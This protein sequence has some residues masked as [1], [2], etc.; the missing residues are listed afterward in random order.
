[1]RTWDAGSPLT[2]NPRAPAKFDTEEDYNLMRRGFGGSRII[3]IGGFG[4]I[5]LQC[6]TTS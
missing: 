6:S 4:T 2:K 5:G 1:M 3:S